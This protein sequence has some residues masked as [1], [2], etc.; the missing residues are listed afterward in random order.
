MGEYRAQELRRK[1][2]RR[3]DCVR[4]VSKPEGYECK[5]VVYDEQLSGFRLG[6]IFQQRDRKA[7]LVNCCLLHDGVP[8]LA[9]FAQDEF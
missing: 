4:G 7:H 6:S 3:S 1:S 9:T 5:L 2:V 8:K